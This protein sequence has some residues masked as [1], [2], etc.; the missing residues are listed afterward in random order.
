MTNKTAMA[1]YAKQYKAICGNCGEYG[2][3]SRNYPQNERNVFK[4]PVGNN[5][6]GATC[7]Y[8]RE[9]GHYTR[10]CKVQKK[11][12]MI[13]ASGRSKAKEFGNV[14]AGEEEY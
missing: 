2:H 14:A 10:D 7:Y 8:C 6:S 4:F 3:R 11:A 13:K 12:N 1:A 9:E 5:K